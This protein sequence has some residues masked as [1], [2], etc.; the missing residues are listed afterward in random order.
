MIEK[1]IDAAIGNK[2]AE[3]VLK[4]GS[5]VNVFTGEIVRADIA[6][7]D[8]KI[9]GFG[10]YDG[11]TEYDIAG[12]IA[13]PGLIDAHVHIESSQLSPEEFAKMILP[14]GTVTVIADPHEITNVC[15]IAGAKYI[16]DAVARTP[17]EVKVII[18]DFAE[19]GFVCKLNNSEFRI[20]NS[21]L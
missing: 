14:R 16:A 5:F 10:E 17:L 1:L 8:G 2:K 18:G 7:Q 20:L 6:I 13:V 15:G 12:K 9:V 21:E 19:P 4:N 3:I 11:E